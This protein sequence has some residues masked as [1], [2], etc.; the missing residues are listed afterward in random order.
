MGTV[1]LIRDGETVQG[2]L[3]KGQADVVFVGRQFLKKPWYGVGFRGGIRDRGA[4]RPSDRLGIQGLAREM[5]G[6][7]GGPFK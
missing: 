7:K 3:D 6:R 5:L 1:G 4:P 2:V